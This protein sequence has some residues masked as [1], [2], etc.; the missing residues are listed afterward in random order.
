MVDEVAVPETTV[1]L[2]AKLVE[3]M[4]QEFHRTPR[5]EE[6]SRWARGIDASYREP[7]ERA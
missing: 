1:L 6:F 7:W 2:L 4:A 3:V 5:S